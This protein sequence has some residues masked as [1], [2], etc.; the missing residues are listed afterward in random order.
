MKFGSAD[1][2]LAA[3]HSNA[4]LIPRNNHKALADC[5][6]ATPSVNIIL[7]LHTH[8]YFHLSDLLHHLSSHHAA[9]PRRRTVMYAGSTTHAC[10]YRL[11]NFHVEK[12][13]GQGAFS[14]VYIAV[15]VVNQ[16]R[17]ALKKVKVRYEGGIYSTLREMIYYVIA[18][19]ILFST[20]QWQFQV[21][22][23]GG[24]RGALPPRCF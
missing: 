11:A 7:T 10:T 9:P 4:Y 22:V 1:G 21:H 3:H 23:R 13:I 17:V 2:Y 8:H 18:V 19:Q 6:N 20:F 12:C 24:L 16:R 5:C 15:C 14:D